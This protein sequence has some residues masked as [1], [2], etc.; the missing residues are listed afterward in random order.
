MKPA[1]PREFLIFVA[2]D[3]YKALRQDTAL[4]HQQ[5]ADALDYSVQTARN[6]ETG[7][8][9]IPWPAFEL[10]RIRN[11]HHLPGLVWKSWQIRDEVLFDPASN[12]YDPGDIA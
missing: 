12:R 1:T 5:V 9:R 11:C 8:T 6:W 7:K 10:M 4:T 2:L 3:E